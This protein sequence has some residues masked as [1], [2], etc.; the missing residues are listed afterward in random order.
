MKENQPHTEGAQNAYGTVN[1]DLLVLSN[2]TTSSVCITAQHI[3]DC[4]AMHVTSFQKKRESENDLPKTTNYSH[5]H[6]P[7]HSFLPAFDHVCLLMPIPIWI[8]VPHKD[9]SGSLFPTVAQ[10]PM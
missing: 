8:G 6:V 7:S 9:T 5:H 3:F 2:E 4:R 1:E 10:E